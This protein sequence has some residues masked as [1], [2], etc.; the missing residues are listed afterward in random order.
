MAILLEVYEE[1][2]CEVVKLRVI[3]IW[4]LVMQITRDERC[5][6]SQYLQNFPIPDKIP[7]Y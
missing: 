5:P 2:T 7:P 3:V 6:A 1:T 4:M